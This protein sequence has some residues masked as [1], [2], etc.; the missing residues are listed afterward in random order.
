ML[1]FIRWLVSLPLFFLSTL[2]AWLVA[3]IAPAF[4]HDYSL[5]DTWLWWS[6]TPNTSLLGDPDHQKRFHYSNSW[7]QQAWWIVRNPAVNFQRDV[8]GVSFDKNTDTIHTIGNESAKDYGGAY[9]Q[10]TKGKYFI[11]AW[12]LYA[13]LPYELAPGKAFR[14]LLGW[15]TWDAGI[16]DPLQIT[17]RVTLWKSFTPKEP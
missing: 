13:I 3:P 6:T 2:A 12:M 7:L 17:F 16:K 15:K 1:A 11:K 14:L 5:K 8:L 9:L 10:Y 4:A